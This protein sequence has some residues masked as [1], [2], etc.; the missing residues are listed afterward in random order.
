MVAFG[1]L[2]GATA[3]TWMHVR[4][5]RANIRQIN[6]LAKSLSSTAAGVEHGV[7]SPEQAAEVEARRSEL[8]VRMRDSTK[9]IVPQLSEAA[10]KAGLDILG[11]K[12]ILNQARR[13]PTQQ[14]NE[15]P[16]YRVTVQGSYRRIAEFMQGCSHQRIPARVTAFRIQ[17]SAQ[18]G[19]GQTLKGEITIEA[20]RAQQAV[21]GKMKEV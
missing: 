1:L 2:V 6:N 19:H 20:F 16:N 10:R 9:Q 18:Q 12:P 4:Q 5:V 7:L 15:Y 8:I 17:P 11:I 13:K 14:N 3:Y 21:L